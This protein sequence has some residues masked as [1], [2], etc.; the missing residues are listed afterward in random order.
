LLVQNIS[1]ITGINK[2]AHILS[3]HSKE[4]R[5]YVMTNSRRKNPIRGIGGDSD[6]EGKC[7]ANRV[8]RAKVKRELLR[9]E[10]YIT[11]SLLREVSNVWSMSKDGKTRL[12]PT[13]P[14]NRTWLAK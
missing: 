11:T 13:D 10:P 14:N 8:L 2:Y 12:D 1:S 4:V 9:C 7:K 3:K 6:K 5:S